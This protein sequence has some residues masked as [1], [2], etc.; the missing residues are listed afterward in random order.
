MVGLMEQLGLVPEREAFEK[1]F[2]ERYCF[3]RAVLTNPIWAR[4]I[5]AAAEAFEAGRSAERER[6]EDVVF[7]GCRVLKGLD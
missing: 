5:A 2:L 3:S 7:D 6:W 4:E 1:W